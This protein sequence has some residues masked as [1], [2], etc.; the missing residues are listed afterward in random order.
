[1]CGKSVITDLILTISY[2]PSILTKRN[3]VLINFVCYY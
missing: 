2:F 3:L 1:V